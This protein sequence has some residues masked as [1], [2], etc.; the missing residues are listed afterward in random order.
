L[1]VPGNKY[2]MKEARKLNIS[3]LKGRRFIIFSRKLSISG[4]LHKKTFAEA[5]VYD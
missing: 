1:G 5:K 2:N 4:N 3:K